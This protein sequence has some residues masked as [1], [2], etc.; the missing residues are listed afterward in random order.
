MPRQ[1]GNSVRTW[2]NGFFK[3][4][5]VSFSPFP[6]PVTHFFALAPIF[7]WLKNEKCLERAENLTETLAT[8]ARGF[9]SMGTEERERSGSYNRYTQTHPSH[10]TARL[11][12][13]SWNV[14]SEQFSSAVGGQGNQQSY[15]TRKMAQDSSYS[16]PT[17]LQEM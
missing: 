17:G 13:D 7:A 15:P 14:K 3:I 4:V 11:S 16:Q 2:A 8:Q 5:G 12:H 6:S 9:D 10:K 1:S